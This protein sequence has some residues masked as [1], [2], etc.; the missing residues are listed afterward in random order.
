MGKT[1]KEAVEAWKNARPVK[2]YHI[3]DVWEAWSNPENMLPFQGCGAKLIQVC[4]FPLCSRTGLM[5]PCGISCGKI[6][7]LL[8]AMPFDAPAAMRPAH[9][10][11]PWGI[12]V[13]NV[14]EYN[15]WRE[16]ALQILNAWARCED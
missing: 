2:R 5:A 3:V 8:P 11:T 9:F 4:K 16:K 6:C 12:L 10:G 1:L 7:Q 15:K 13:F 14:E